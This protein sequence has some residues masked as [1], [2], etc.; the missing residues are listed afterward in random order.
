MTKTSKTINEIRQ[1][2]ELIS[3]EKDKNLLFYQQ[4]PRKGV[5]K[6]VE[7]KMKLILN[8]KEQLLAHQQRLEI[9]RSLYAT[10]KIQTIAGIDEVGRGPLAGPLVVAAVI[11]P[12]ECDTLVGVSDSK[13]LSHAKRV[14]FDRLIREVALDIQVVV[15]DASQIDQLNIYEATRQAMRDAAHQLT[16]QPDYLL[17]DAM[18]ID[19]P[20]P[21][22]S[23]I[24]GDQRS[25]SIAAASIIAKVYRDDI[26]CEYAKIFPEF[27]FERNMGYGTAG[28][29]KAL[30]NHG[31]TPIHRQSFSPVA[32]TRQVYPL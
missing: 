14:E 5:Q 19:S 25:L 6:L 20:L 17:L 8:G 30:A 12:Q 3:D 27:E 16:I 2:L 28:H 24:K 23:L 26:M 1:E 21:Q 13:Q 29:L 18:T 22:E 31:Y 15:Y 4:D 7:R 32:Q 10:N 11:L 9:E